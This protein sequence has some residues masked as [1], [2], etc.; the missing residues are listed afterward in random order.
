M[1]DPQSTP[2]MIEHLRSKC[3][4][5]V[6]MLLGPEKFGASLGGFD[7]RSLVPAA[8]KLAL[9]SAL[10]FAG[11]VLESGAEEAHDAIRAFVSHEVLLFVVK[12]A[13]ELDDQPAAG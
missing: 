7:V 5:D 8:V 12:L 4:D 2:A 9:D 11:P 3:E 1:P 10:R 13:R 6:H